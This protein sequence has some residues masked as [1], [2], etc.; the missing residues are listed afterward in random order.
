MK[1]LLFS[2][3]A[4]FLLLC[5]R[6]DARPVY[7][8]SVA[9]LTRDASL[10]VV[11]EP[12]SVKQ[13]KDI[14]DDG[15]FGDRPMTNYV[16][17]ETTCRVEVVLKGELK[18]ETLQIVHF[19]YVSKMDFNGSSFITFFFPPANLATYPAN[20]E[21][22]V[23]AGSLKFPGYAVGKPQYLA[24]LRRLPDG[25]FAPVTPQYDAAFSF[26]VLTGPKWS[27]GYRMHP[28]TK[29]VSPDEKKD[30]ASK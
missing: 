27:G 24:F 22:K 4:L 21:D 3:C 17:L 30:G 19:Q 10:V 7:I 2:C 1:K 16:P 9:E 5:A 29:P 23:E 13:T 14:P 15:S 20:N 18:A 11:I 28:D 6:L 26:K 12:Q 25:R 8:P